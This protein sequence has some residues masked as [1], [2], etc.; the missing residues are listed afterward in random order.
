MKRRLSVP[1]LSVFDITEVDECQ[2]IGRSPITPPMT[3]PPD[4]SRAA[5]RSAEWYESSSQVTVFIRRRP[6][7]LEKFHCPNTSLPRGSFSREFE[8]GRRGAMVARRFPKA[9]VASSILVGGTLAFFG[10]VNEASRNPRGRP[11][12]NNW[13]IRI[14][15]LTSDGPWDGDA[16][17]FGGQ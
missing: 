7:A 5:A 16:T 3:Y 8:D 14:N 13:D 11:D 4:R 15:S 12:F 2:S 6:A 17:W 9:K 1:L 10:S